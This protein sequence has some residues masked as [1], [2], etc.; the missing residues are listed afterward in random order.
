MRAGS[1]LQRV[2]WRGW[3]GRSEVNSLGS[4]MLQPGCLRS[5]LLVDLAGRRGGRGTRGS[6]RVRDL[7]MEGP[8]WGCVKGA[9]G[10]VVRARRR[11]RRAGR[12]SRSRDDAELDY[13]CRDNSRWMLAPSGFA[14]GWRRMNPDMLSG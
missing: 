4:S 11:R 5:L 7:R 8:R 13:T 9:R 6:C 12:D 14:D 10:R 2:I 1:G 3:R